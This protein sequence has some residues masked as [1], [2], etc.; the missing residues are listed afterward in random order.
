MRK[1]WG[2]EAAAE[3]VDEQPWIELI[4]ELDAGPNRALVSS[5][6]LAETDDEQARRVAQSLSELRTV[7]LVTLRP[8]LDL[9]PSGY[10]QI[11]K[12]GRNDTYEEWL[13]KQLPY[14]RVA[15]DYFWR[16]DGHGALVD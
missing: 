9:V 12:S 7:V 8:L 15:R 1:P 2:W 3:D 10:Q 6:F 11:L 13:N 4:A 16:R 14:D 5:E